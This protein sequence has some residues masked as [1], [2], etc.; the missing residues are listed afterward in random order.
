[1]IGGA[2]SIR[3]GARFCWDLTWMGLSAGSSE[4]GPSSNWNKPKAMGRPPPP[5][6]RGHG[7]SLG[8]LAV[9]EF[10]KTPSDVRELLGKR[11]SQLGLRLEGSPVERYVH[12][13]YREL[14]RKGI[15]R[16]HPTC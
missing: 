16:F 3:W 2:T 1:M 13:L 11:I 6:C 7:L 12:Q 10:E 5:A 14:E 8:C 4:R 15:K 9:S